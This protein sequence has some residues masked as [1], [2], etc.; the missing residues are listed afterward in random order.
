M[1]ASCGSATDQH[2]ALRVELQEEFEGAYPATPAGGGVTH[3]IDLVAAP[4]TIAL[5]EGTETAVW[6]YNDT[7]PGPQIRISLGDAVR[8][9]LTNEL[10]VPT[11]IHWH[12][13]RV[14]NNMDGVPGVNQDH[15]EPGETFA[16]EFTP[17][18]AGTY[19]YHSHTE[20][21]EQLERGLYGSFIVEDTDTSAEAS[22]D[23]VWVVDDW[24]LDDQNQIDPAFNTTAD[25]T[26]SGRWGNHMT[27]NASADQSLTVRPGEQI[28]LRMVNASNGRVYM[29]D[30]DTIS[31]SVVAIDGLNVAK[32][33][34]ADE[35]KLAPGNRADF[36]I[37]APTLPG[38]YVVN[39][40][41]LGTPQALAS[42]TVLD[43]PAATAVTDFDTRQLV[44]DQLVPEWSG[45]HDAPIDHELLFETAEV[46][47]EWKWFINGEAFPN[48]NVLDLELGQFTKIRLR[49]QTHPLHPIHLH[50]VFFKVLTRNGEPVDE[51]YFR[52]TILLEQLDEVEI[53]L[54]PLDEGQ[55]VLH[56]HIQ[57]H[58]D[59][60]MMTVM[61]IAPES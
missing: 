56:C 17:P 30:F 59:A 32:P 8:V 9:S 26:H 45:A 3:D 55:W 1:A 41:Y 51:P 34:H 33:F 29:P 2:A 31:A 14:P 18:D 22:T 13:I 46:D 21:S 37:Q 6:A 58:A 12:G 28:R 27:V 11:T 23:V 40:M 4:A 61:N 16:Y 43:E 24:L 15:I 7:V 19:W 10:P 5:L 57:E 39:D 47:G 53:G 60:G 35:L 52:D 50:G 42:I 36:L 25:R 44:P 38:V 20:G 54:V 49:N 48:H